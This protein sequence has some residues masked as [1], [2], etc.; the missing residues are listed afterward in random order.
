MCAKASHVTQRSGKNT[1]GA[2][3]TRPHLEERI[4]ALIARPGA[5]WRDFGRYELLTPRGAE[6]GKGRLKRLTSGG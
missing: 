2:I 4:S 3:K 1:G 6:I 5:S